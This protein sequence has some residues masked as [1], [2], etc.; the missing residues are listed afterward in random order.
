MNGTF[1]AEQALYSVFP[2]QSPRPVG[3]GTYQDDL[4]THFYICGFVEM[5]DDVPTAQDWAATVSQLHLNS[6]GKSPTGHFGFHV[7]THLANVPVNNTWN[8][9]WQ[10][11]WAQHMESLFEQ[12]ELLHGSDDE[13]T[14]LKEAFLTQVIP[15]FLDP[16]SLMEE[17]SSRV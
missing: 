1:E 14:Q 16:W 11:F 2:E 15:G 13:V 5:Y 3:W 8:M 17:P 6:M 9:S 7:T 12:D 4:D 10:A